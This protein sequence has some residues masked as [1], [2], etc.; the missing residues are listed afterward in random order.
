MKVKEIQAKNVLIKSKLPETYYTI[1][2]YISCQHACVYC[3]SRFMKRFTNHRE[4]WGDF[5]DVKINAPK[6]L[7]GQLEKAKKKMVLLSSVCDPYQPLEKKYKITR[8]ILEKLVEYQFSISIL[9]KSD[10]VLRDLDLSF[11]LQE[12]HL[13]C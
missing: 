12:D 2:P 8:R 9:T 1:N 5:V 10:L 13:T 3:Y 6:I 4:D 7:E 11:F